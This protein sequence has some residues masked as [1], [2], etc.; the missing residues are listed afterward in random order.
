MVGR[1][2]TYARV[3]TS[4]QADGESLDVQHRMMAGYGLMRG[5][6]VDRDFVERG[7]SGSVP[8][9]DRPA[10]GELLGLVRRGDLIISA[11]LD[12]MFRSARDALNI[13]GDLKTGGISL[14]LIDLGGDVTNGIS[15]MVFTILAAVAQQERNRL[16]ER[17]SEAKADARARGAYLG[18]RVP[19]GYRVVAGMLREDDEQQGMIVRMRAARAGGLSLRG[20]RNE[21]RLNLSLDVINR[22]CCEAPRG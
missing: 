15:E 11:K 8:M 3:S 2:Y 21:L 17:V 1:I 10:G 18:G 4:Q 20:V 14:H 12:R 9:A 5:W 6:R 16:R 13:L 22:I 7:V 19:Y